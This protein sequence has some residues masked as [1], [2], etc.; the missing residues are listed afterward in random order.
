MSVNRI[1]RF[2]DPPEPELSDAD[3]LMEHATRIKWRL[4]PDCRFEFRVS[5][6]IPI[7]V[8]QLAEVTREAIAEMLREHM[9][10]VCRLIE[11]VN[12]REGGAA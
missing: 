5:G 7:P 10:P 11:E 9:L 4:T 6:S 1:D 12:K 2:F 8:D 3:L